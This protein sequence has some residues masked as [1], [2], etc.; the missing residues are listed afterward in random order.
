MSGVCQNGEITDFDDR[1]PTEVYGDFSYLLMRYPK[2]MMNLV[3][4]MVE[5][6]R[7]AEEVLAQVSMR[8]L[9]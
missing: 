4:Q 9:L 6:D 2:E 3:E 7:F 1:I 5:D 8:R